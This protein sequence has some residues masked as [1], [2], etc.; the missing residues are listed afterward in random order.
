MLLASI[1]DSFEHFID[2]PSQGCTTI[3]LK[4]IKAALFFKEWQK[5]L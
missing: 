2:S 5:K 4:K 3:I 1:L